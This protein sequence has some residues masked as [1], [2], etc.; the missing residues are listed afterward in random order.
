[1]ILRGAKLWRCS[2]LVSAPPA[3]AHPGSCDYEG[4]LPDPSIGCEYRYGSLRPKNK[5]K[6]PL[7]TALC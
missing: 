2:L 5:T 3:I 7:K 1:V 6:P 4:G